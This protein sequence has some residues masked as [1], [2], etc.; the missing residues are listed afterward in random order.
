MAVL[1]TTAMLFCL[2][3]LLCILA[4]HV[5]RQRYFFKSSF[6]ISFLIRFV[7]SFPIRSLMFELGPVVGVK[8]NA[9]T[10]SFRVPNEAAE[11]LQPL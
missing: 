9:A 6:L 8:N 3:R 5:M 4:S 10:V 11:T 1:P 2:A 7:I